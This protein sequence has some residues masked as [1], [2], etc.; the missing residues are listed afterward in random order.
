MKLM[1]QIPS[2]TSLIPTASVRLTMRNVHADLFQAFIGI[3]TLLS[4]R[5]PSPLGLRPSAAGASLP[6]LAHLKSR[7]ALAAENLF[8][9]KTTGVVPGEADQAPPRQRRNELAHGFLSRLFD[10]RSA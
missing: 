9:C 4:N 6:R 10:W 3:Q 8:L 7:T 5:K 1:S 2:S